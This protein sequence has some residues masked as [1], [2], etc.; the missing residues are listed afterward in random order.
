MF[1]SSTTDNR[2]FRY[3]SLHSTGLNA[4]CMLVS[5]II[6][7]MGHE[8]RLLIMVSSWMSCARRRTRICD[9]YFC[10]L[11]VR[12]LLL[13]FCIQSINNIERPASVHYRRDDPLRLPH[14]QPHSDENHVQQARLTRPS[15][16]VASQIP[17]SSSRSCRSRKPEMFFGFSSARFISCMKL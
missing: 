16:S 11:S 6:Q 5:V 3:L 9:H 8:S 2:L 1:S 4:F 17:V 7:I 13:C 14:D 10:I 15:L 12:Q